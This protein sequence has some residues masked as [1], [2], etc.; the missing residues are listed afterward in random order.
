MSEPVTLPLRTLL[1]M[2]NGSKEILTKLRGGNAY[3]GFQF[4]ES[5]DTKELTLSTNIEEN[6]L[7]HQ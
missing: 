5:E 3:C 4:D 2:A 1:L 6:H 7:D